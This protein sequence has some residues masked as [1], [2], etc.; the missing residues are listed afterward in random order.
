MEFVNTVLI[1]LSICVAA[2]LVPSYWAAR[3]LPAEGVRYE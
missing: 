3:L 1:A 2:G